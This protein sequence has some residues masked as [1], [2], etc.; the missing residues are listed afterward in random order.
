MKAWK[1]G[2]I[3][4][5]FCGAIIWLM[6]WDNYGILVIPSGFFTSLYVLSSIFFLKGSIFQFSFKFL[7]IFAYTI[8]GALSWGVLGYF[9]SKKSVKF[10]ILLVI[11]IILWAIAGFYSTIIV[12]IAYA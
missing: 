7:N 9:L 6:G 11:Y 4:G 2:A 5:F 1:I 8:T 3:V 12:A 10:R